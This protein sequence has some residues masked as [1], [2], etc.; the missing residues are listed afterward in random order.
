MPDD[1]EG[2]TIEDW[3]AC[4]LV[5]SINRAKLTFSIFE[6]QSCHKDN[7]D[8]KDFK[9]YNKGQGY[10]EYR[11]GDPKDPKFKT[12][13]AVAAPEYI[14]LL[15]DWLDEQLADDAIFP[16]T[17]DIDFPQDFIKKHASKMFTR[18]GRYFLRFQ[19]SDLLLFK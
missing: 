6:G 16:Q 13:Q 7:E 12:P 15:F 1:W 10:Y 4:K 9:V 17:D 8:C 5:D 11:W 18:Y 19:F 14:N 3:V 2:G